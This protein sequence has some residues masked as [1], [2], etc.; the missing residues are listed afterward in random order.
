[1]PVRI[2]SR[3]C[4]TP[5][6]PGNTRSPPTRGK[7]SLRQIVV[8]GERLTV[9]LD[10]GLH[11]QK[12]WQEIWQRLWEDL[13][14]AK[15]AYLAA[16][17]RFDRLVKECPSGHPHPDGTL[18]VQQVGRESRAALEG[19]M[20]ALKR[21]TDFTLHGTIPEDLLPPEAPHHVC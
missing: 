5:R 1:M 7:Q 4:G 2:L 3:P 14:K 13:E 16:D 15:T 8:P 17:G 9:F 20:K 10:T 18:H 19:Y 6:K 21:F 12:I 11:L